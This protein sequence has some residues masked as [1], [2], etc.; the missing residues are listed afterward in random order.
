MKVEISDKKDNPLLSRQEIRGHLV[1]DKA[2]PS[3]DELAAVLARQ[4]NVSVSC[5]RIKK[6]ET[7]YG[8]SKADF[9]ALVYASEDAL[10]SIE[11]APKKW[12]EKQEKIEQARK[13]AEEEKKK[14]QEEAAKE[15]EQAKKGPESEKEPKK[16]EVPKQEPK[17]EKPAEQKKQEPAP[18]NKEASKQEKKEGAE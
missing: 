5:I 18:E 2:T 12:L 1:F 10:D 8:A 14:A 9:F 15:K 3:N 16:E 17:A 6:I 11:P 7:H 4:L 13:K